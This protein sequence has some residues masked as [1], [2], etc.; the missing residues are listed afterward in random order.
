MEGT[1]SFFPRLERERG[2]R[3]E[4]SLNNF[5]RSLQSGSTVRGVSKRSKTWGLSSSPPSPL[6]LFT[7]ALFMPAIACISRH[8]VAHSLNCLSCCGC[9]G[10]F[11]QANKS[12]DQHPALKGSTSGHTTARSRRPGRP[13]LATLSR[14][15][16]PWLRSTCD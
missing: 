5:A 16:V 4:M 7:S 1:S 11:A 10:F 6:H 15:E 9:T 14:F 13:S 2:A 8:C 3:W 12:P